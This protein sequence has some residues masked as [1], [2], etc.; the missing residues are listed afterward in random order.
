ML[1]NRQIEVIPSVYYPFFSTG[2]THLRSDSGLNAFLEGL[3]N[4]GEKKLCGDRGVPAQAMTNAPPVSE[5]VMYGDDHSLSE[6]TRPD[7][8]YGGDEYL[9][10]N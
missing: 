10:E 5:S 9:Y 8:R 3:S 7:G 2:G 4:R 1:W 6:S